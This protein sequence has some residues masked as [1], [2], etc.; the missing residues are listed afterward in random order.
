MGLG[1]AG[2]P[3]PPG[4]GDL[5]FGGLRGWAG[6]APG[7]RLGGIGNHVVCTEKTGPLCDPQA[8][9]GHLCGPAHSSWSHG[10]VACPPSPSAPLGTSLPAATHWPRGIRKTRPLLIASLFPG[11]GAPPST[12]T[13]VPQHRVGRLHAGV[14]VVGDVAM[15]KP[16]AGVVSKQLD[17]LEGARKEVVHVFPVRRVY[18][19]T[20]TRHRLQVSGWANGVRALDRCRSHCLGRGQ[21]PLALRPVSG[22]CSREQ[23]PGNWLEDR[24][25]RGVQGSG[26]AGPPCSADS[27]MHWA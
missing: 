6:P 20:D 27:T 22:R 18:L 3:P 8:E 11:T 10:G 9:S 24:H 19:Q 16:R 7:R 15:Q 12:R 26:F 1:A 25:T 21:P 17:G 2:T 13:R 4:A 14:D 5:T 23:Q